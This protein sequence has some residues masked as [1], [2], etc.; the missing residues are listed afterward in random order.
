MA[1]EPRT[2]KG[3][4]FDCEE[5]CDC[6]EYIFVCDCHYHVSEQTAPTPKLEPEDL[7]PNVPPRM[8]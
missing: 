6:A 4:C 8:W 1:S 5:V 2:V 7:R 3:P